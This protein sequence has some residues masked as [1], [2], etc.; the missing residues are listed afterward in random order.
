MSH[1]EP[2]MAH[3]EHL[4]QQFY[5]HPEFSLQHPGM[6][7]GLGVPPRVPLDPRV[8]AI[9]GQHGEYLAQQGAN[10][11]ASMIHH[12][13]YVGQHGGRMTPDSRPPSRPLSAHQPQPPTT[14]P[15]TSAH[16]QVVPVRAQLGLPG[17]PEDISLGEN[18]VVLMSVSYVNHITR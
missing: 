13:P 10:L 7:Y 8:M 4:P 1:Q 5:H 9:P 16:S 14:H 17:R 6:P 12:Q 15:G 2:R 11:V 18:L 3:P